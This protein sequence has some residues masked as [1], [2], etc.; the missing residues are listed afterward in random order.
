MNIEVVNTLYS[1]DFNSSG[2]VFRTCNGCHRC[3]RGTNL[4][5]PKTCIQCKKLADLKLMEDKKT[6]SILRTKLKAIR[7]ELEVIKKNK[8]KKLIYK[9]ITMSHKPI[10]L[11]THY[12]CNERL[13]QDGHKSQCCECN[14]HK[15]CEIYIKEL[16]V[17]K[18]SRLQGYLKK[19]GLK[20]LA[21]FLKR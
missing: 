3:H 6:I 2:L 15:D 10:D 21:K 20:K 7:V 12:C 18:D 9:K 14:P 8:A 13:K 19:I 11:N 17:K 1:C 5:G 16:V 4:L